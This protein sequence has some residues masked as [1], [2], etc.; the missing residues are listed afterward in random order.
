MREPLWKLKGLLCR[1]YKCFELIQLS[2]AVLFDAIFYLKCIS[3]VQNLI[4]ICLHPYLYS[5][6]TSA[7]LRTLLAINFNCAVFFLNCY[8]II[9]TGYY[10]WLHFFLTYGE[11]INWILCLKMQGILNLWWGFIPGWWCKLKQYK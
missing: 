1:N 6:I 10:F 11:I 7:T 3:K 4:V 2:H 5:S 9:S 8:L